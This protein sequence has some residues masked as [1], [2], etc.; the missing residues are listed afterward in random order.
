MNRVVNLL[1]QMK[2]RHLTLGIGILLSIFFVSNTSAT[3][4]VGGNMYYKCLGNDMYEI[5]FEMRRDCKNGADNAPHRAPHIYL[6]IWTRDGQ[7]CP[8]R[9]DNGYIRLTLQ[10]IDTLNT[11]AEDFCIDPGDEVCVSQATYKG[12][13][14][15]PANKGGHI[16]TYQ[17]CCRNE[18]LTN[19]ENPLETGGTW[20]VDITGQAM[21]ECNSNPVFNDW[22]PIYVCQNDDFVFDHSATDPDGDS[23]AYSLCTPLKGASIIAPNPTKSSAPPYDSIDWAAP[24]ERL[25]MM[26]GTPAL[27]I[28]PATGLITAAPDAQGTYLIGVVVREYRN[29]SL[30]GYVKRDFQV[31]VVACGDRPTVDFEV[32]T[33]KCDGLTQRF[34]NLSTGATSYTWFF[35]YPNR[36]PFSNDENPEHTYD[37][38]GVYQVMLIA[39]NDQGCLDSIIKTI[40]VLDPQLN[41]DFDFVV[42]CDDELI[43]SLFDLSTSNDSIVEWFWEIKYPG[44][45]LTSN[46][47][48]PTFFLNEGGLIVMRLTITDVNGCTD[49][50]EKTELVNLIDLEL[51]SDTLFI[52]QGD[53]TR[54]VSNGDPALTYSW[55]PTTGLKLNVPSDPVACPDTTTTYCVTATDGFCTRTECVTVV[56]E[57]T[58]G[59]QVMGPDSTC[60]GEVSLMAVVSDTNT[61]IMWYL[62]QAMTMKV[63]E[64]DKLDT[65]I[66]KTTT[67]YLTADEDGP[68]PA[69]TE[70]TVK[71]F[72]AVDEDI[73]R[74]R[75]L[76]FGGGML[77]L[78]PNG[79][80][81]YI[82]QWTPGGLLDDSTSHNPKATIDT[83]TVFTVVITNPDHPECPD[84]LQVLVEVGPEIIISG[85]PTD[86]TFCT[87]DSVK[88]GIEVSPSNVMIE[89]CDESGNVLG[90]GDSLCFVPEGIERVVAKITDDLGCDTTASVNIEVY[91]LDINIIAPD[92]ICLG[93]TAMIMIINNGGDSLKVFWEP[94]DEII[95]SNTGLSIKVAPQVTTTYTAFIMDTLGC[96]WERDINITVNDFGFVVEAMADPRVINPG[97]IVDLNVEPQGDFTYMWTGDGIDDPT[98]PDPTAQPDSMG[99]LVYKVK[100]TDHNGCMGM[101]TVV[102]TV[103]TPDCIAGVFIPNAFSPNG[104]GQNDILFVRSNFIVTMEL[105]IYNRWGDLLFVSRSINSGWDGTYQGQP[106]PPDVYGYRLTY[107]C[108]DGENYL[109]EGNVTLIK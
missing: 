61:S 52:C 37:S 44:G 78:N 28:D 68:C 22:P 27:R 94:E 32:L 4:V 53:S 72:D 40:E 34:N 102:V 48:N 98:I 86:T 58:I 71:F 89:W 105:Q 43:L 55:T 45:S 67:W 56:V 106:L 5:T 18:I 100:L 14:C 82:Y 79:N 57:D 10:R 90:Q 7:F 51:L 19:I 69:K 99:R 49:F 70:F 47:Q 33:N 93:D 103:R 24:F 25:D 95:G 42:E 20:F 9:G 63:G 6:S 3:H 35:D 39:E 75:L 84:T 1:I 31:N 74:S 65:I 59:L 73:D 17:R 15:L 54:L 41:A 29:D 26:G 97:E 23:L 91:D 107:L 85:L 76:C 62:D 8:R 50:V 87:L 96:M 108:V 36:I 77:E 38:V 104:D 13:A 66:G 80:P 46:E 88:L 30:I 11:S 12:V 109:K 21:M 16:L 2:R 60:N 64:G 101:D 92:S 81:D 83:T